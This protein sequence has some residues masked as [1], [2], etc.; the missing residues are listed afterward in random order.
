MRGIWTVARRELKGY[1]DQP[2]AYV[3]I[4]AFLGITLFLAFRTMYAS[5]VA[6]LRPIFDLLPILFAI[7]VPAATMRSLAEERRSKTL[8]WLLA[9]PLSEFEVISG[10]FLGD[11]LFVMLALAGTVPTAIGVLLV[12]D[13]D[14]GIMVAQYIGAALLGAQFVALG[15]WASSFTRNQITAFIVAAAVAFT[16]F[17]I[18]L[19]IVQIG[20]PPVLAGMLGRLSVLNHFEN[21]AR[22]VVDLRDVVYFASTALLFL[23]L[24]LGAVQRDR[25]SHGRP[26]WQRMRVGALVVAALVVMVNL[27]GSY[28][29]GRVDL[30][31]G[32]L[33]TLDRGT[34]DLLGN[35][36]D[37]VQIKL[38][39]STQLPP[40]LQLQLRDVQDLLADMQRAAGGQLVVTTVDPDDDDDASE[41]ASELGIY[42]VEFNVLRDDQFEVRRGYYGLA[43]LYADKSDVTPVIEHPEDLEFRLASA[44]YNMTTTDRPGVS[45]VEGYGAK[46]PSDIPGLAESLGDRY[47]LRSINLDG[48]SAQAID[49]D[50]TQVVVV[51][52]PLQPLDSMAVRRITDFADNGGSTLVL[53]EPVQLDQQS[54]NPLPVTSG[55]EDLLS[56]RGIVV[57]KRLVLDLASSERVNMGRQGIFQVIAPYPLW[58]VAIPSPHAI[59]SGLQSL[60]MGWAGELEISDSTDVQPLWHTSESAGL[61]AFAGPIYPDQDWDVPPEEM[62]VRTLAAAF[63]P[64]EGDARGR[65]VVVGDVTFAEPQFIQQTPANLTFLANAID[66]LAQDEALIAIRSKNRTPPNL[67]FESDMSRNVL[68][69]GNLIGVPILF[70]LVGA[71]RVTGRRRRAEGR[72]KEVVA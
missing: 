51:A 9:Q 64:P 40:E 48:D 62:H 41:E 13:A 49:R 33:Y 11:W 19:P 32:N 53:A 6:S 43:V 8:E 14:A 20:V 46:R 31:S 59:T 22:G 17:L 38:F 18:G 61:H 37:L 23:V 63:T 3:L 27:L 5:G 45:F 69:W 72:W 15:L 4:V 10:K 24:A 68:K 47:T 29:R 56:S 1:F 2:T 65:M 34:R 21:V 55:L 58:P 25:L 35:L 26:E 39:A 44:I 67:L 16:L 60:S 12:S 36:D 7:F 66:W 54:P 71:L 70:V 28:V 52:G 50:S 42:P 30:T 57:S